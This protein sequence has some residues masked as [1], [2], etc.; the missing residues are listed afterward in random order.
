MQQYLRSQNPFVRAVMM[1]G[2]IIALAVSLLFG[3]VVFLIV[4]GL[5]LVLVAVVAARL[6]WFQH[7]L[8]QSR[9]SPPGRGARGGA[10]EG[11]YHIE[12]RTRTHH[13]RRE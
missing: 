11:E 12:E 3:F 6:W 13:S 8:R 2:A 9:E 5:A 10:I 4:A 7:K 1:T